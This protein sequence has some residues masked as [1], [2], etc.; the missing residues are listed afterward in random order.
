MNTARMAGS[1]A[2]AN[3]QAVIACW[4]RNDLLRAAAL[5]R[6]WAAEEPASLEAWV[7]LAET[8]TRQHHPEEAL[9]A[10]QKAAAIDGNNPLF[11]RSLCQAALQAGAFY[12]AHGA[13]A[14]ARYTAMQPEM[15][16]ELEQWLKVSGLVDTKGIFLKPEISENGWQD[17][18]PRIW[19]PHRE[20]V[21]LCWGR[22]RDR[23]LVYPADF[24]APAAAFARGEGAEAWSKFPVVV[25]KLARTYDMA[26]LMSVPSPDIFNPF[27][28]YFLQA[29][30]HL[31]GFFPTRISA[32][33]WVSSTPVGALEIHVF[34]SRHFCIIESEALVA[35]LCTFL[36]HVFDGRI[37]LSG[38]DADL[39]EALPWL[40]RV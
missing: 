9:V 7:M 4:L 6:R 35:F 16:A 29:A 15:L 32:H 25:E 18:V 3:K 34:G 26:F 28:S 39:E 21:R 17:L 37:T 2:P 22:L 40:S 19:Q 23:I 12:A 13:V 38:P 8:N 11:W 33:K 24:A 30:L 36:P 1:N 5:A 31:C 14:A 10:L 20:A 27:Q